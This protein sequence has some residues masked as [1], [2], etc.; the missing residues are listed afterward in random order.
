MHFYSTDWSQLQRW[1]QKTT[2]VLTGGKVAQRKEQH[3]L[4]KLTNSNIRCKQ[5]EA[6]HTSIENKNPPK[7]NLPQCKLRLGTVRNTANKQ[8]LLQ[9]EIS[10][11]RYMKAFFTQDNSCTFVIYLFTENALCY[12]PAWPMTAEQHVYAIKIC[13]FAYSATQITN[14]Q[15]VNA[16]PNQS[17]ASHHS[18]V[19]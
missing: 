15:P 2:G 3:N 5:T 10:T 14:R 7:R 1:W 18:L 6:M 8:I 12:I 9:D 11:T 16:R 19:S 13:R 4:N 17:A